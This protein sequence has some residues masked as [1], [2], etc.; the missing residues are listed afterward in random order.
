MIGGEAA[1]RCAFRRRNDIRGD[2]GEAAGVQLGG[3]FGGQRR[4]EPRL[5][6]AD[7]RCLG[8][9]RDRTQLLRHNAP[10]RPHFAPLAAKNLSRAR[11]RPWASFCR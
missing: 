10:S 9:D 1:D 2:V 11:T 6:G 7:D 3:F 4:H 8:H 5:D